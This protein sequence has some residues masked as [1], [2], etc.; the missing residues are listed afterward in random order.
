M[1]GW[2]IRL[3]FT[4]KPSRGF[5]YCWKE[6]HFIKSTVFACRM[7]AHLYYHVHD[8]PNALTHIALSVLSN[9]DT[10]FLRHVYY[11]SNGAGR[12]PDSPPTMLDI[13]LNTTIQW[14]ARSWGSETKSLQTWM[15]SVPMDDIHT[16]RMEITAFALSACQTILQ[17]KSMRPQTVSSTPQTPPSCISCQNS[18][19]NGNHRHEWIF[20]LVCLQCGFCNCSYPR[21]VNISQTF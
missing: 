14:W 13:M 6:K 20:C 5:R 10:P 4:M 7:Q 17:R 11:R 19:S 3:S 16:V 18:T 15:R 2:S 9:G 1:F 12:H 21:W 8:F